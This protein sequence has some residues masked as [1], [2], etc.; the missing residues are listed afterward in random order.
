ML[1]TRLMWCSV[2]IFVSEHRF[3]IFTFFTM[4]ISAR[5]L[6]SVMI[7]FFGLLPKKGIIILKYL[8]IFFAVALMSSKHPDVMLFIFVSVLSNHLCG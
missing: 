5:M 3:E 8:F 2:F 7:T 1:R 6:C 4:S